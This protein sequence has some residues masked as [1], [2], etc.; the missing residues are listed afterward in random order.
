MNLRKLFEKC[1]TLAIVPLIWGS[2]VFSFVKWKLTKDQELL[3]E[4]D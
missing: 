2:L 4:I 1:L 3:E